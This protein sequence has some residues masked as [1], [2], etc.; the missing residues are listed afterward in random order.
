MTYHRIIYRRTRRMP[1]VKLELPSLPE[2]STRVRL[3]PLVGF[4]L[5][6][7]SKDMFSCVV[8]RIVMSATICVWCFAIIVIIRFSMSII[9]KSG[10]GDLDRWL[11]MPCLGHFCFLAFRNFSISLL[12]NPLT[13]S[14]HNEGSSRNMS[15]T[16]NKISRVVSFIDLKGPSWSWCSWIYNYMCSQ[17]I[18]PLKLCVRTTF[19]TRCTRYNIMW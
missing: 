13:L 16:L 15:Y 2:R 14:V 18:S 1:L 4:L 12:S 8:F 6:L 7:L 3:R 17:C 9:G 5:F 10:I 19:V 11:S